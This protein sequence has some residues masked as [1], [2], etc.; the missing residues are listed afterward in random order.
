MDHFSFSKKNSETPI[1]IA[2]PAT[3]LKTGVRFHLLDVGFFNESNFEKRV[4]LGDSSCFHPKTPIM[5][6]P[7]KYI[8][9]SRLA[10]SI[11]LSVM[12]P[13]KRQP[14]K[15]T[16]TQ[17][18][19]QDMKWRSNIRTEQWRKENPKMTMSIERK[20]TR[21]HDK[22]NTTQ[23]EETP[24]KTSRRKKT[25][26]SNNA[27]TRD[28]L[29]RKKVVFQTPKRKTTRTKKQQRIRH[30]IKTKSKNM[31]QTHVLWMKEINLK[32]TKRMTLW[33]D[34]FAKIPERQTKRN[35]FLPLFSF[36][37]VRGGLGRR[38]NTRRERGT[39]KTKTTTTRTIKRD[40]CKEAGNKGRPNKNNI[41][42]EEKDTREKEKKQDE[43]KKKT[44]THRHTHTQEQEDI[45]PKKE[46][47]RQE[48]Q[49]TEERKR[50]DQGESEAEAPKKNK[51]SQQKHRKIDQN[52]DK[53][54]STYC[55][56][57]VQSSKW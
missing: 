24:K 11:R 52:H 46:E 44:N 23:T 7:E 3:K 31:K 43:K 33:K 25:A 49:K 5:R 48:E 41:G 20:Q 51:H 16:H 21:T 47:R 10:I 29:D 30:S 26:N 18:S 50:S 39:I 8:D 15:N 28:K 57:K 2:F 37:S 12:V 27:G 22:K 40:T 42:H 9:P 13:L 6:K 35:M 4:A 19:S 53:N 55:R 1:F 32:T 45:Q 36:S 56:R 54:S 14:K 34:I 17:T 38:K